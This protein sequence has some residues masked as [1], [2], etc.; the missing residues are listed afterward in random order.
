MLYQREPNSEGLN[1]NTDLIGYMCKLGLLH[2]HF[3]NDLITTQRKIAFFSWFL[4]GFSMFYYVSWLLRW[5][6]SNRDVLLLFGDFSLA[7]RDFRNDLNVTGEI[8]TTA[9]ICIFLWF[10]YCNHCPKRFMWLKLMAAVNSTESIRI[11]RLNPLQSIK[12]RRHT[13]SALRFIKWSKVFVMVQSYLFLVY[14]HLH[15]I[16]GSP[17]SMIV[18]GIWFHLNLATAYVLFGHFTFCC[19]SSYFVVNYLKMRAKN[20][21][22]KLRNF[23]KGN[24]KSRRRGWK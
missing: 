19:I 14:G 4:P 2:G 23:V 18:N 16:D 3:D 20:I 15:L 22:M 5:F 1:L 9:H 21:Q 24:I 13:S 6:I 7:Y 8:Y 17:F 12:F 10:V 11:L